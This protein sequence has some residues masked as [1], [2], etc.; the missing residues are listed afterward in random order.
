MDAEYIKKLLAK[1]HEEDIF[2]NECRIGGWPGMNNTSYMDGWAMVK[3]WSTPNTIGYEVKVSRQDFIKDNKWHKYLDFCNQFY[4][5]CPAKL[6]DTSEVPQ[7]VG[8]MWIQKGGSK[9]Y[10]KKKAPRRE[11]NQENMAQ[12]YKG[13]LMNR[14]KVSWVS[15]YGARSISV[16]NKKKLFFEDFVN[17]K[18]EDRTYGRLLSGRIRRVYEEKIKS[19]D[20]E[21]KKLIKENKSLSDIKKMLVEMDI[22]PNTWNVQNKIRD[23]LKGE[24]LTSFV[25]HLDRLKTVIYNMEENNKKLL[26]EFRY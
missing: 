24:D 10:T 19:V 26:D 5:V 1:K 16:E 11:T 17:K 3:S 12:L 6:I 14:A 2:V 20:E 15:M 23:R 25:N 13:I 18:E 21:N 8:M 4:F 7:D 22:D 9:L